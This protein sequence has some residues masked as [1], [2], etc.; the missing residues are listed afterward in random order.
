VCFAALPVFAYVFNTSA[1]WLLLVPT[2]LLSLGTYMNGTA[3]MPYMLSIAVGRPDIALKA[4]LWA[5]V[6]VLPITAGLIYSFGLVGAGLSWVVY[7]VVIYASMIP[8]I[9]RDCLKTPTR[10]WF[11]HVA[12]VLAVGAV[13][14]G[15]AW[16]VIVIPSGYS[17]AG[18]VIGYVA[19]TIGFGAAAMFLIGPDLKS[20]IR[21]LTAAVRPA[22]PARS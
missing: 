17:L 19:A 15:I 13:T 22:R 1:A 3:S 11:A 9:C 5:L 6:I 2:V 20:T 12:K 18:C 7:H 14:Y 21:S 10:D 4:N 16:I 8:R